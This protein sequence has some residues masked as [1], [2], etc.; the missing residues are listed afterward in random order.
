MIH[1]QRNVVDTQSTD[2]PCSDKVTSTKE[3]A[4]EENVKL[5]L[6]TTN[7]LWPTALGEFHKSDF[8]FKGTAT[9][10]KII[11]TL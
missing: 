9:P 3:S 2:H 7:D 4:I 10:H 6:D 1:S 8:D 5:T 11:R